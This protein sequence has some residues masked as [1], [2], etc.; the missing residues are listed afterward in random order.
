MK[1]MKQ[2]FFSLALLL[3]AGVYAQ[4]HHEVGL[5][6]GVS[7]YIGDLQ[8]KVFPAQGY[9][10]VGGIFY[11]YFMNPHLG[12]RFGISRTQITGA[13]SLSEVL[14]KRQRNLRFSS[15]VTEVHGAL[16]LN[17][18]PIEVHR[19]KVT[20]YAFAGLAVYYSNPFADGPNSEKVYLRPLGTEGQG[21]PEYPDRKE[22]NLVNV[23][24]PIGGGLKF[25]IGKT[26]MITTELGFRYTTT[27][28]LD[29]VSK[30]YV[31]LPTLEKYKGK[32][33]VDMAYRGDESPYWDGSYYPDY[34]YQRGDSKSND[35]YWFGSL[36]VA[37]YFE[38]FGNIAEYWQTK[39]PGS[40]KFNWGSR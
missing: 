30:S 32:L 29:D 14:L 39:C 28:Y 38:A 40:R 24:F 13:D 33:A 11:K 1:Q 17:M 16:E 5:M 3:P 7:N 19:M 15:N 6:G 34:K 22:Y 25:F 4:P 12:V 23:A 35:W 20:P 9:K 18:L 27:D 10:P 37:I 8:E 31:H 2:L 26:F 21:L 36:G